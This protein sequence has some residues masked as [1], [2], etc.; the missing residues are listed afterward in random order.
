ML[1]EFL[2]AKVKLLESRINERFSKVQFK[3]FNN[4]VNGGISE[5]CEAL[6]DGV[7][8]ADANKASKLN[9]G[10][11]IINTLNEYYEV[12]APIWID[13]RESVNEVIETKA[14]LINLVVSK[15]KKL[16]VKDEI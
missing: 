14:Q 9:A 15:E 3:L 8:F 11:D 13:N 5:T 4:Q 6:I 7:P 12:T 16:T 1:E 2:K 10:L